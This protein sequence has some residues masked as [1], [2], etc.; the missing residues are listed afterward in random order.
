MQTLTTN[1]SL[2]QYF[3]DKKDSMVVGMGLMVLTGFGVLF[4]GA[5]PVVVMFG[6]FSN[7]SN[8]IGDGLASI[9]HSYIV[10]I[11]MY[12]MLIALFASKWFI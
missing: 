11:V 5:V 1:F 2:K 12:A 8:N 10:G 9:A 6:G 3:E 7:K 4:L